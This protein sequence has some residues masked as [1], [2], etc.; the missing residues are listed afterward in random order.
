MAGA[1][2]NIPKDK[3]AVIVI[4]KKSGD[5]T[6]SC[7]FNPENYTISRDIGW[8]PQPIKGQNVPVSE[9]NGGGPNK[10]DLSLLFDTSAEP[11]GKDVRDYTK[12]LWDATRIDE[13]SKHPVTQ[14]G[15]PPHVIF[16]W[17]RSWSFEAVISS[18]SEQFILFNEDGIPIRSSIKIGLTQV[19]DDT[20]FG[21]Q[22]PTSGGIPGKMYTVQEG[23]RLDLIAA[24]HYDKPMLWRLIAE[25]NEI[26]NPRNLVPGQHLIIPP[27]S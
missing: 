16:I 13:D 25:Y 8:Q 6:L 4:K 3:K 12:K 1:F 24:Q 27:L 20:T 18:L 17:G 9:F 22:N 7:H 15:E 10:T 14:K 2:A 19:I 23:D 21:K 5:V 26:D 11:A